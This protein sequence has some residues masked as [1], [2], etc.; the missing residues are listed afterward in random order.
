[1]KLVLLPG[2]DGTGILFE[3]LLRALPEE[4]IP[5]VQSYPG[6]VA[7]SY[8]ELLPIAQSALPVSEPFVLLGESFSG[9][10]ALRIAAVNPPGLTGVI[11]CASFVRNPVRFFPRAC[12]S[13]IQPFLFGSWPPWFRCRA[14]FVGY[15]SH[16]MFE[17][18]ER[19]HRIVT[20]EVMAARAREIVTVDAEAALS[21]C[22]VPLLYIAGARD[23]LVPEYNRRRIKQ[24]KPSVK[25]VVLPSPHMVLQNVPQAAAEVIAEFA[26][27][28]GSG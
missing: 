17:L 4:L 12:R 11:L 21:A 19:A 23:R 6:D 15:A 27:A 24:I 25:V 9:P 2:L 3:P 16:A 18:V 1:M 7:L 5:I 28:A 22:R 10:L 20:A 8:D 13:L 26:A 14:L